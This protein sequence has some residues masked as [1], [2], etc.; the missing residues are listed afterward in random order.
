LFEPNQK[1]KEDTTIYC[2]K[3]RVR[4]MVSNTFQ[5]YFSYIVADSY[6]GRGNRSTRR[7]PPTYRKSPTVRSN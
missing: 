2:V 7:K 6:I 3:Y 5:I 4:V 1:K